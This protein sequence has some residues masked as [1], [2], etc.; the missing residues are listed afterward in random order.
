MTRESSFELLL[1]I[2]LEEG[3]EVRLVKNKRSISM[4]LNSEKVVAVC[5]ETLEQVGQLGIEAAI[6][7]GFKKIP[8]Q[9]GAGDTRIDGGDVI[10]EDEQL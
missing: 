2:L 8:D 6:S 3:H 5:G 9:G 10:Y 1:G 7:Y 4:T